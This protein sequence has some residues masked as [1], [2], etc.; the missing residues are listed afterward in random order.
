MSHR[1]S[2]PP[3]SSMF[4]ALSPE[5]VF[6]VY[7]EAVDSSP[8]VLR[9]LRTDGQDSLRSGCDS[10][11]GRKTRSPDLRAVVPASKS[12]HCYGIN[13][14][15]KSRPESTPDTSIGL[16]N[17]GNG[18]ALRFQSRT[19]SRTE[20]TPGPQSYVISVPSNPALGVMMREPKFREKSEAYSTLLGPGS[21]DVKP[22]IGQGPG[23]NF[24]KSI[25]QEEQLALHRAE[26]V[27]GPGHY[28][29][30]SIDS[31]HA[32]SIPRSSSPL[33]TE[34]DRLGPGYYRLPDPLRRNSGIARFAV[35]PRFHE[36]PHEKLE[37]NH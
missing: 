35:S 28:S 34:T 22:A 10:M 3:A 6:S 7:R 13:S 11:R 30:S 17:S 18:P 25:K 16:R 36:S 23:W 21:Y 31:Q 2:P 8:D 26:A 24:S 14:R 19:E 37:S 33:Y 15:F 20:M 29:R 1:Y 32:Y 12:G 9:P 5:R 27:P 4:S